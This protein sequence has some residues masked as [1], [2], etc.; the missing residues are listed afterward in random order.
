MAFMPGAMMLVS[1]ML[2]AVMFGGVVGLM[3]Y[4]RMVDRLGR[5]GIGLVSAMIVLVL[6]ERGPGHASERKRAR[7]GN[8]IHIAENS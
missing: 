3:I 7:G 4:L 5:L 1:V 8:R 2:W 6:G